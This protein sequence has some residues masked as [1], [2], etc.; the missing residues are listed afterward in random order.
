M[1][2]RNS[3]LERIIQLKD[4]KKIKLIVGLQRVDK[5]F[6]LMN[7]YK[8]YLIINGVNQEQIINLSLDG[9][10]NVNLRNAFTLYEYIKK[11]INPNKKYY[12][13]IDEIQFVKKLSNPHTDSKDIITFVDVVLGLNHLDNVDIYITGSNSKMLSNDIITQMRGKSDLIMVY[14][15]A[16]EELVNNENIA[17]VEDYLFYGRMP[18]IYANKY[19][20][21]Q[22]RVFKKF[23]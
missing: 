23:I 17:L 9:I 14:S 10:E 1:I 3:Y 16:Y 5:R 21:N 11:I 18:E 6:L 22:K 7:L 12:I 15:L 2:K 13:F 20:L 19:N 8:D 4:N